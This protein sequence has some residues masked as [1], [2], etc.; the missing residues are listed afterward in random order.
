MQINFFH[1]DAKFPSGLRKTSFRS[2][3]QVIV[4]NES[5]KKIEYINFIA[6]SDNYVLGINQN[7][8]KHDYYTDVITFDY[9][10]DVIASDVFLSID[11][12]EDNAIQ[13]GITKLNECYRILIH[14]VLHLVGYKDKNPQDK[15]AMVQKEN[16]YLR[17]VI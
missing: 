14:S 9:S 13:N 10:E 15:E 3:V 7:Y 11:R 5:K 16:Y 8:L 12:I 6:G 17:L 1:E 2:V 4:Q